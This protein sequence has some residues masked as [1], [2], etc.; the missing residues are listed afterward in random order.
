[1]DPDRVHAILEENRLLKA[2]L[3][4]LEKRL[5][6]A[7]ME[8]PRD[9]TQVHKVLRLLEQRDRTLEEIALELQQK[10][11]ELEDTVLRLEERNEQLQLWIVTLGLYQRLL[12]EDPAVLLGFNRNG[13]LIFFNR[14]AVALFGEELRS[15]RLREAAEIDFTAADP[16]TPRLVQNVLETRRSLS[17]THRSEGRTLQTHAF[18]VGAAEEPQGVLVRISVGT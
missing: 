16:E 6:P 12:D 17:S 18:P 9:E 2:R 3:A 15:V 4:E 8:P 10:K 11:T 5:G 13:R 14:A 7:A 1:M